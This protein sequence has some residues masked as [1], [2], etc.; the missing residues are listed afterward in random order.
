MWRAC[1]I[2]L[3]VVVSG[4]FVIPFCYGVV[5]GVVGLVRK[6]GKPRLRIFNGSE[7]DSER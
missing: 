5:A 6:S 2:V 7:E 3:V 4:I 1:F